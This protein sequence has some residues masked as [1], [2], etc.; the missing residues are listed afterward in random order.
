MLQNKEREVDF[1]GL[2]S[3][4]KSQIR[5]LLNNHRIEVSY[6]DVPTKLLVVKSAPVRIV[7]DW[8]DPDAEFALQFV[9]PKK[10]YYEWSNQSSEN[11]ESFLKE[12]NSSPLSKEFVID[13]TFE[14]EWMVNLHASNK[15]SKLPQAFLKYTIYTNYGLPN[16]TKTV[17]FIKLYNYEEKVMLDKF[18]I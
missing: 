2:L 12:T 10:R 7:F 16:E 17:K 8:N 14:G 11:K 1:S 3:Q 15:Y 4:A 9:N 18:S 5:H 6:A 13:T